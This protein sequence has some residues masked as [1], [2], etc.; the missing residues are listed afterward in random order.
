MRRSEILNLQWQDIDFLRKLIYIKNTKSGEK[1]KYLQIILLSILYNSLKKNSMSP[2]IF[3]N[4]SGKPFKKV[5]K[6]FKSALRRAGIRNFTF[7]DLR[8]TFAS[9]LVMNGTDLKTVQELLG[10][11]TFRMTLRYAHLS[12]DYKRKAI[13]NFANKMQDIVTNWSQESKSDK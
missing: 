10:H 12:P 1:K 5:Y 9:H 2:Y 4:R 3:I 6:G 13:D 8:H 11:K 7:H